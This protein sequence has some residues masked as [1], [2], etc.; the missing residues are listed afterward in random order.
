MIGNMPY[1][2]AFQAARIAAFNGRNNPHTYLWSGIAK[3]LGKEALFR[4]YWE[5]G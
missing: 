2:S 4:E 5:A 1:Q 3:Q